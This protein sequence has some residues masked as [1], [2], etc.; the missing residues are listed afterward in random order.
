MGLECGVLSANLLRTLP[1]GSLMTR[2]CNPALVVTVD[3]GETNLATARKLGVHKFGS[4]LWIRISN[5]NLTR[6]LE[7]MG[8]SS[9]SHHVGRW[10]V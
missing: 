2:L 6:S 5:Q 7:W 9:R 10:W 4:N 8:L 3:I 1:G